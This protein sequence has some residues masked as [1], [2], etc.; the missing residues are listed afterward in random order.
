VAE[1]V[2]AA[3][4]STLADQADAR[5]RRVGIGEIRGG[6]QRLAALTAR[7]P[8]GGFLARRI[9]AGVATLLVASFLIFAATNA[10]PG[11]VAQVV[12]GKTAT[13]AQVATLQH[14]LGLNR[15][16]LARY[17]SWLGE[18][19]QG[20][21]G[22]S[23]VALAQGTRTPVTSEIGPALLNSFILALAAALLLVPLALAVGT[24]AAVRAGTTTDY[25][26]SYTALVLGA[27]P[28]FVFG[29]ILIVIFFSVLHLLPP[30]ALVPPGTSPLDNIEGLVLPV[31]T[32]LGVSLAFSARQVRAG[33]IEA[34]DQD[35]VK[36]AR[37]AGI[38][39]PRVVWRYALRNALA[40]SV[41]T[42]GQSV[43]YLFGG[44]IV[45]ETLF[46]YPGIGQLLVQSVGLRDIT[47]VQ[48]IALV[49]AAI[50]IG[51]NIATD[52]IV[53]LLVPKLRTGV[54]LQ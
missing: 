41:Q 50:Y 7:H 26:L 45:V 24:I 36:M 54:G 31:M 19:V 25:A 18:A 16:L 30:L 22:D 10:L 51:V 28:E 49:L 27:L 43:Q 21:L 13:P 1:R 34:L 52:L 3:L 44:I 37:L 2:R 14:E 33:V 46:G 17:G 5:E 48:G 8:V 20:N 29:T 23:A 4:P 40:P 11:N 32:L 12:L 47:E 53:V 9:L 39:E 6:R 42:F 38:R 35:Y 15:P